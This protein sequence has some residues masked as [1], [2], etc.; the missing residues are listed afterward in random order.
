MVRPR[1]IL[2]LTLLALASLTACQPGDGDQSEGEQVA[3]A[4]PPAEG[5]PYLLVVNKSSNSLSVVDP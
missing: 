3:E 2:S 4:R 1:L 5:G